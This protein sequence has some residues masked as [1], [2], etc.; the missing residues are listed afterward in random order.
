MRETVHKPT[1]TALLT[2]HAKIWSVT[3]AQML[4]FV[5]RYLCDGFISDPA[6]T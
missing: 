1:L 5:A 6:F 4:P 2:G 3:A